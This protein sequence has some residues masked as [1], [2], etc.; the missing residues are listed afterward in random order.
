[1][2][3]N[4]KKIKILGTENLNELEKGATNLYTKYSKIAEALGLYGKIGFKKENDKIIFY[5]SK[6]IE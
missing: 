3:N 6:D 1:M 4:E 2:E 5:V